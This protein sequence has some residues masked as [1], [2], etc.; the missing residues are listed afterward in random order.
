MYCTV[1]QTIV[2]GLSH[3]KT[4]FHSFNVQ[5]K[6]AMFPPLSI[7]EIDSMLS[8]ASAELDHSVFNNPSEFQSSISNQR[9]CKKCLFCDEKEALKHYSEHGF[10]VED[11]ICLVNMQC[12]ICY[13]KFFEK[14]MLIKHLNSETHRLILTD[15]ISL[16][17]ENGKVLNPQ[18]IY[19]PGMIIR[20]NKH[21]SKKISNII[22]G[23]FL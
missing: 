7:D 2:E 16:F 10:S 9:K 20:K 19:I 8:E 21:K 22:G 11:S 18:K 5:R 1:C 13:E 4:D 12:F 6:M 23:V 3:Y 14:D 15:G 17:L